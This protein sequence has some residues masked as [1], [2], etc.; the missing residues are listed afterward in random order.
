MKRIGLTA[1]LLCCLLG[2][3]TC[4]KEESVPRAFRDSEHAFT[5]FRPRQPQRR[6]LRLSRRQN[7]LQLRWKMVKLI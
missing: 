7:P 4:Q 5:F 2:M 3:T 1:I 6:F